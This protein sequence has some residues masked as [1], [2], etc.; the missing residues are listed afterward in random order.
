MANAPSRWTATIEQAAGTH[1]LI[2]T[3]SA[4]RFYRS[5]GEVARQ[6]LVARVAAGARL[7]W[8]PLETIAY[9]GCLAENH[10]RFELAPGA[11]MLGWEMLALGLPAADEAFTR[12]RITQHLELPGTWLERGTLAAEDTL[13]LDSPL[14]LGGQRVLGTLWAAGGEAL[15][16]ALRQ[17]LLDAAREVMAVHPLNAGA[18]A[19]SPDP[20]VVVSRALAP[21]V[22]PLFEL[23]R[24]IRA[25]WRH[26]LWQLD[27]APPRIW[28]M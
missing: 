24:G 3:P 25:R 8:L 21:R 15:A 7:E 19:T 22:E 4:T 27:E 13:L 12:G 1:A 5:A 10:L 28:R 16:P 9:R 23:W 20:A 17:A 6:N 14:G 26:L 2:T 11:L 18:G